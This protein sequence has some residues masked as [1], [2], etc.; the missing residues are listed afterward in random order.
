MYIYHYS[1]KRF[2]KILTRALQGVVS[3][4]DLEKSR[5]KSYR[6]PGGYHDHVS[7]FIDRPPLDIL[8]DLFK[9]AH[10]FW[11]DGK[12]LYEYK[13]K[14]ET[15]PSNVIYDIVE[16]P[17]VI[18]KINDI[19][20][21]KASDEEIKNWH[22]SKDAHLRSIKERGVGI[23]NLMS[24]MKPY[25]GK[26]RQAYIDARR[27]AYAE[28]TKTM[29]AAGV[30]HLMLYVNDPIKTESITQ[31]RVGKTTVQKW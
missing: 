18:S 5:Q 19:D 30:P 16:T 11:T 12:L 24:A 7:F 14:V 3:K 26:T 2:D 13:V 27:S 10:P 22:K 29:Y 6:S 28:S 1:T 31:V 4:E 20:W 15:L 23:G 21:D 17:S 8:P 25:V 9:G